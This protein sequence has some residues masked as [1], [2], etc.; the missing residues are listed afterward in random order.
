M[1]RGGRPHRVLRIRL[2]ADTEFHGPRDFDRGLGWRLDH[3]RGGLGQIH[4]C[5]S[6]AQRG[7]DEADKRNAAF[8]FL[9]HHLLDDVIPQPAHRAL[10]QRRH[11]LVADHQQCAD[12]VRRD[13]PGKDRRD[14]VHRDCRD[15]GHEIFVLEDPFIFAV[16]V[17]L[18]DTGD[19]HEGR[20][21]HFEQA[22]AER[23]HRG[24]AAVEMTGPQRAEQDAGARG[25]RRH[26]E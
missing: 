20:H 8:G 14:E 22:G 16:V 17:S 21:R 11:Q 3:R 5:S 25:L 15:R 26:G 6:D 4:Q 13:G 9:D 12:R 7:K 2:D 10:E 23:P 24:H 1:V 19:K 18:P